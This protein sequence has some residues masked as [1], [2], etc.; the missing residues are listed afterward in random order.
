M[1]K[2]TIIL[3]LLFQFGS[4]HASAQEDNFDDNN[5]NRWTEIDSIGLATGGAFPTVQFSVADGEYRIRATAASPNPGVL[6]P[7]RGVSHRTDV[8]FGADYEVSYDLIGEIEDEGAATDAGDSITAQLCA[9]IFY[10]EMELLTRCLK[11]VE[12]S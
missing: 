8:N 10:V 4:F 7:A 5:S 6:G 3:T 1:Q 2:P 11:P 12:V 9:R